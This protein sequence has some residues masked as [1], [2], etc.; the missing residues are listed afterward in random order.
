ML[1]KFTDNLRSKVTHVV[2]SYGDTNVFPFV[3]D[4]SVMLYFLCLERN[5]THE[6]YELY[7]IC[8]YWENAFL[9][10]RYVGLQ[11]LSGTRLK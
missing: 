5:H 9:R 10:L 8:K 7:P 11:K 2:F 1:K 4:G 6:L 3:I